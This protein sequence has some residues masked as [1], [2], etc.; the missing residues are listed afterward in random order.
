MKTNI[1]YDNVLKYIKIIIK[2]KNNL[3]LC[4]S[5]NKNKQILYFKLN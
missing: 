1:N 2:L 5:L 3:F 4:S